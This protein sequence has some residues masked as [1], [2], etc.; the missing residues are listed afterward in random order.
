VHTPENSPGLGPR[1][2]ASLHSAVYMSFKTPKMA[3]RLPRLLLDSATTLRF[4]KNKHLSL[5][6]GAFHPPQ[7]VRHRLCTE[8]TLGSG[9]S[10]LATQTPSRD[11][12]ALGEIVGITGH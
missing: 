9:P 8:N 3:S 6:D 5:R 1:I 12:N 4:S 10:E 2:Q 11:P 7:Q